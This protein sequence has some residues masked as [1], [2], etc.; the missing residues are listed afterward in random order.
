MDKMQQHFN[1]QAFRVT[2]AAHVKSN[3]QVMKR[4]HNSWTNLNMTL[5]ANVTLWNIDSQTEIKR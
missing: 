2:S 5:T 1:Q 4:L 3:N